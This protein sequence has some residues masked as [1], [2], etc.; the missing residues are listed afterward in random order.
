MLL[1]LQFE[2][3][4]QKYEKQIGNISAVDDSGIYRLFLLQ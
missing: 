4:V 2:R 3:N 1:I